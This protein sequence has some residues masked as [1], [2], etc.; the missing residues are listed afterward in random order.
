MVISID[1]NVLLSWAEMKSGQ[2]GTAASGTGSTARKAPTPPWQTPASSSK[3][4]SSSSSSSTAAKPSVPP[5]STTAKAALNGGKF[6]DASAAQLD[7]KGANEQS[8]QD[9]KSL[10]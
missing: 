5:L 4:S 6:F 3:P 1:P 8:N 9:Y 7:V 10:F 2:T